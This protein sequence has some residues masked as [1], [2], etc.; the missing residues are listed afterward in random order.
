MKKKVY[1]L[2]SNGL[3]GLKSIVSFSYPTQT[4]LEADLMD[5]F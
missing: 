2:K 1:T 5:S 4:Y 3:H